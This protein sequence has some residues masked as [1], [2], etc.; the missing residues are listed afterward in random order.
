[1]DDISVYLNTRE[2]HVKYVTMVLDVLKQNKLKIKTEKY[3]FHVQKISFL[4]L[5]II[6]K[7]IQMETT[8]IDSI[9]IWPAPKN[10]KD[11]QKL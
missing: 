4:G 10:T 11:L 3:R 7:N 9:Q 1:M 8:K 5:V 6:P 2:K